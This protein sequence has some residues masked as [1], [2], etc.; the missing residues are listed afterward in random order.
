M[1]CAN[2]SSAFLSL[3]AFCAEMFLP[4]DVLTIGQNITF[5][6]HRRTVKMPWEKLAFFSRLLALELT[7]TFLNLLTSSASTRFKLVLILELFLAFVVSRQQWHLGL[8]G[9]YHFFRMSCLTF[10]RRICSRSEVQKRDDLLPLLF[11]LFL[12]IHDGGH[13]RRGRDFCGDCCWNEISK[14]ILR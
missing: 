7:G 1:G 14:V 2:F 12:L 8:C 3:D 9:H 10:L 13:L 6:L 11:Q 4:D 5:H